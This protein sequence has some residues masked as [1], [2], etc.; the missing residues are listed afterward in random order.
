MNKKLTRWAIDHYW[1]SLEKDKSLILKHLKTFDEGLPK[2]R[3]KRI[4]EIHNH[5]YGCCYKENTSWQF[6]SSQLKQKINPMG[7]M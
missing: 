1:D 6:K 4:C 2:K 7:G 5:Y 3:N